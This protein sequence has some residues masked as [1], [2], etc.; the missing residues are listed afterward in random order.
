MVNIE[1]ACDPVLYQSMQSSVRR[2]FA[3][4]CKCGHTRS[5][6]PDNDR[7]TSRWA[8]TLGVLA[9]S[10]SLYRKEALWLMLD[11][12]WNTR[13]MTVQKSDGKIFVLFFKMTHKQLSK[14]F[15]WSQ[16]SCFPIDKGCQL[17]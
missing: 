12:G 17:H 8:L 7:G 1:S 9:G 13:R 6:Q 4:V 14:R 5:I 3:C 11:L 16:A 10:R 2:C 15:Y